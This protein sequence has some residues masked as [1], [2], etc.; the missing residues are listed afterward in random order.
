M[1]GQITYRKTR[2]GEWVVMGPVAAVR[3]NGTVL[4]T[5]RDGTTKME[6][7]ARVG[8]PFSVNGVSMVYGH[9]ARGSPAVSVPRGTFECDECGEWARPGT[10][11]WETGMIH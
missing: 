8:S 3:A 6:S 2:E 11:C 9:I 7:I 1:N 5:R 10:R 4:V